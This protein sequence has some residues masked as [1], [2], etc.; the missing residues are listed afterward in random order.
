MSS[1]TLHKLK[2]PNTGLLHEQ[3][4]SNGKIV[5]FRCKECGYSTLSLG[6]LH[7]HCEKH[8]DGYT[9]FDIPVPF[10]KTAM[11]NVDELM[12]LTEVVRVEE[13]TTISLDEVE[14]L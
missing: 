11:G 4:E 2:I 13:T 10:T 14:G 1:E 6:G 8:R 3:Y 9:R 7:A 12:G 5:L